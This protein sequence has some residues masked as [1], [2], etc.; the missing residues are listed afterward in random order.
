[1]SANWVKVKLDRGRVKE[2]TDVRMDIRE[3]LA[4]LYSQA[5]QEGM[6]DRDSLADDLVQLYKANS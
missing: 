5:A 1:M 4:V 6:I 2:V 3:V